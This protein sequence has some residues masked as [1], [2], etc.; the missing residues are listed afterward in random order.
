MSVSSWSWRFVRCTRVVS[1]GIEYFMLNVDS[2]DNF[3]KVGKVRVG[4]L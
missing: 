1:D 2:E 4:G 3:F